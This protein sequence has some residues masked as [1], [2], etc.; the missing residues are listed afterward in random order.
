M[1]VLGLIPARGGSQRVPGKNLRLLGGKPLIVHSI[2][3]ALQVEEMDRVVVTTDSPEIARVAQ[4][5]GADVPFLRP[6]SIATTEST[7]LE[8]VQHALQELGREGFQPELIVILY[9]TSPFRKASSI[10]AAIRR[11][12]AFP[13]ADSLRSVRKCSEHPF[14]MWTRESDWLL[15]FV[16]THESTAH[17]LSYQ[18]LPQVYV[19]NAS[20]YV[21]RYDTVMRL[22]TTVGSRVLSFEMD[23]VESIDVNTELDFVLAEAMLPG[24]TFRGMNRADS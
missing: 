2:E 15:P 13:E 21:A 18:S 17:T 24:L 11:I 5:A 16:A 8:F 10:A 7:E 14:K 1:S 19:Q 23:E 20:I 22:Q 6:A 4:Q 3:A 12:R 9:P